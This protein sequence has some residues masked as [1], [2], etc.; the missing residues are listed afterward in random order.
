MMNIVYH[1]LVK[2]NKGRGGGVGAHQPFFSDKVGLI[3]EGEGE[4]GLNRGFAVCVAQGIWI[5]L[6]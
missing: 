3:R 5:L 6:T 1:L 4:G 2:I